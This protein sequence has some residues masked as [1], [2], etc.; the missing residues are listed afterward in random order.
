MGIYIIL[1]PAAKILVLE[2][3]GKK[4]NFFVFGKLCRSISY[5]SSLLDKDDRSIRI[6]AGEAL[7]LIF[8]IG[9]L[10]KF[11]SEPNDCNDG[12]REGCTHVRG[13]KGKILNQVRN[14]SV[15]AGGKG[16][17]KKDLTSQRNLFKD[18]LE[19]LEVSSLFVF[20]LSLSWIFS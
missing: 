8:E 15:E 12:S 19:F 18:I 17:A 4:A 9:S 20:Q 16:S 7:A 5:F 11:S 1:G 3:L 10:E 13:L 14:L 2:N 6:A